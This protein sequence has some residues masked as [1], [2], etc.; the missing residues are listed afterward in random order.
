MRPP[1]LTL[2]REDLPVTLW[3]AVD[4]RGP[5]RRRPLGYEA[6]SRGLTR[7]PQSL[8]GSSPGLRMTRSVPPVPGNLVTNSVARPSIGGRCAAP[9][10]S[11]CSSIMR[12]YGEV[13][14]ELGVARMTGREVPAALVEELFKGRAT[15]GEAA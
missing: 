11:P 1:S 6:V 15:L 2:P 4:R 9:S 8:F 3:E 12:S 10:I 14:E 7:C 13:A 5:I